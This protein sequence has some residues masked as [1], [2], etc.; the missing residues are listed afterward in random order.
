MIEVKEVEAPMLTAYIPQSKAA[1]LVHECFLQYVE[2]CIGWV[3][4]IQALDREVDCCG[5]RTVSQISGAV[6]LARL[7]LGRIDAEV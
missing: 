2:S 6:A 4:D 5:F 3:D 1:Q 7:I